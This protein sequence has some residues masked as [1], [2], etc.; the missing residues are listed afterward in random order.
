LQKKKSK[1]IEVGAVQKYVSV[2]GLEKMNAERCIFECKN[3]LRYRRE[4]AL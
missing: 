1:K 3:L 2:V 4:R